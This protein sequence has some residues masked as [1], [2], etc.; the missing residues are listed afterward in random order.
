MTAPLVMVGSSGARDVEGVLA[1][2]RTLR[3][4]VEFLEVRLDRFASP[5]AVDLRA[6]RGGIR[7]RTIFTLRPTSEGGEATCSRASRIEMHRRADE[8]GFDFVDLESDIASG[9]PRGKAQRIVSWHSETLDDSPAIAA[10]VK[11]L[12][13]LDADV[14]KVAARATDPL[15]ALR[16]V[17]SATHVEGL[18]RRV[19]AIA[20]GEAGRYLRPLAAMFGMPLLYAA[21][22]PSRK[23][24]DGQITVDQAIDLYR[25]PNL[26]PRTR[27]F[28]ISGQDVRKSASPK[29]HNAVF[30]AARMNAVYVD[31][32]ADDF[33]MIAKVAEELPLAGLSVTQPYK[34]DALAFAKESDATASR[35]GAA[36]TLLARD[37]G[38][39]A[40]QNTDAPGF[41]AA[42]DFA[43]RDPEASREITVG[44]SFER[45]S[46]LRFE[47]LPNRRRI[48]CALVYGTG[49]AARAAAYALRES[50]LRVHL[51]G[52][53]FGAATA[54]VLSLATSGV[55]GI[56]A[57]SEGRARSLAF[58]LL[59]KAVP[60]LPDDEV[61]LD[62]TEFAPR[63]FAADVVY[64]PIDTAF[65][66]AAR[67]MGRTP[68]PG[69]L[70]F[71]AQ[72][73]L[74]AREF[75]GLEP[76]V[77]MPILARAVAKR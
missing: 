21:I 60:D 49:G 66:R 10:R 67:A 23:T 40:A 33:G 42:I 5:E 69:I 41:A 8:A 56:E 24:A 43:L 77:T 7:Q 63:G 61:P 12:S 19:V 46:E 31:L 6:L 16:F 25:S 4:E 47:P 54:L 15:S 52:R 72:A 64:Q 75:T 51:T 65:L 70:M 26:D 14:V 35:V 3:P 18:E 59:V 71:V 22:H 39:F 55:G 53:D 9:I 34:T 36:N 76:S 2:S 30:A 29:A 44:R 32:S 27:V 68:I 20:M 13:R 73:A 37:D 17:K 45:M 28:A 1:D 57:I 11:A 62:P 74:Q 58:D 50:G 38:S 48:E